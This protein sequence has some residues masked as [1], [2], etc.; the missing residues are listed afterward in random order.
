MICLLLAF[1]TPHRLLIS[2]LHLPRQQSRSDVSRPRWPRALHRYWGGLVCVWLGVES[3]D[4]TQGPSANAPG[5]ATRSQGFIQLRHIFSN[6]EFAFVCC[7]FCL[8]SSSLW[9]LDKRGG[10]WRLWLFSCLWERAES[11]ATPLL[12]T[13]TLLKCAL[14]SRKWSLHFLFFF[15]FFLIHGFCY[16]SA[17]VSCVLGKW[18]YLIFSFFWEGQSI[19]MDKALHFCTN[20]YFFGVV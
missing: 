9:N 16:C 10:L 13:L 1:Q 7:F 11:L 15:F 4:M 3:G 17:L 5:A 2:L 14:L 20:V 6:F 18:L 8:F 12:L 19:L